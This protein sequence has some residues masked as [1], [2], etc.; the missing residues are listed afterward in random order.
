MTPVA[1]VAEIN[2]WPRARGLSKT[3]PPLDRC[4]PPVSSG[5]TGQ[6][7]GSPRRGARKA[8]R[9]RKRLAQSPIAPLRGYFKLG[10]EQVGSRNAMA[11]AHQGVARDVGLELIGQ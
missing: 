6:R 4:L 10:R 9:I 7:R 2:I 3:P 11:H 5:A 8:L 1:R